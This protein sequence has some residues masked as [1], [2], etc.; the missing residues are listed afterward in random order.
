MALPAGK[1]LRVVF[2]EALTEVA[3]TNPRVVVLDGDVASST[4]AEL[5]E[6]EYPDRFL[7]MGI[8]EQNML[9][10]AAGLA[11][12]GFIPVISAFACFAVGRGFDSYSRPDRPTWAERQ[13]RW[14]VRRPAHR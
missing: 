3:Q 4:G 10:V 14:R 8:A 12:V 9:G 1:A 2:G 6:A 13:D 7:Q 5:F 11:T